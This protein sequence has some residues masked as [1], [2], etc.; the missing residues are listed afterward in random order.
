M[1]IEVEVRELTDSNMKLIIKG[2]N[3]VFMNMLRRTIIA[4]VP[5]MAINNVDFHH[6]P[7]GSTMEDEEE[8]EFESSSPIFDEM[9]AHR[10]AMIPI[11][12]DLKLFSRKDECSCD[13]EGCPNCTIMYAINKRGPCTVFSGDLDPVNNDEFRIKDDLIPIVKLSKGQ[14]LLA[15]ATAELGS[16]IK[17]ATGW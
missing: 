14:A 15:Y 2:T 16:G 8:V 5:K 7:L 11:P 1:S 3:H 6:G 13:G 4:D 12:T 10:L 9:I 17:E